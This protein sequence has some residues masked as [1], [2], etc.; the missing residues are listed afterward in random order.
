MKLKA[1]LIKPK[2]LDTYLNKNNKYYSSVFCGNLVINNQSKV[3][4]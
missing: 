1:L 3:Y 4:C 2:C